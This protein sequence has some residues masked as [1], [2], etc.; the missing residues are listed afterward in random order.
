MTAGRAAERQHVVRRERDAAIQR[1]AVEYGHDAVQGPDPAH[2]RCCPAHGFGPWHRL[3]R[4]GNDLAQHGRRRPSLAF[5]HREQERALRRLAHLA[6]IAG[7]P[8]RAEGSRRS[9][10]PA[11]RCAAPCARCTD[12][13][14]PTATRRR[15][16]S[17]G[18]ASRT[19]RCA[20]GATAP[21]R[22]APSRAASSPPRRAPA[23]APES[24]PTEIRPAVQACRASGRRVPCRPPSLALPHLGGGNAAPWR[25][26]PPKG[27]G[28][29]WG[30]A[31]ARRRPK[32]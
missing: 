29:G 30:A 31:P 13:A 10:G 22:G 19:P 7:Q 4:L 32:Q 28:S 2:R 3:R 12:P 5:D 20:H 17:A 26:P 27:G 9:P 18:A 1:N 16:T 8:D 6:G 24:P 15:P 11:R 21:R 23:Y 14:G 25:L